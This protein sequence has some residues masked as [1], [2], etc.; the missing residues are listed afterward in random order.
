M[1]DIEIVSDAFDAG[2]LILWNLLQERQEREVEPA[3]EEPTD[4]VVTAG[5][6]QTSLQGFGTTLRTTLGTSVAIAGPVKKVE[7]AALP[8]SA[9]IVRQGSRLLKAGVGM[10]GRHTKSSSKKL[11]EL[12]V[13]P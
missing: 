6:Q 9:D 11:S 10:K 12:V 8:F 13:P 7:D 2:E 4:V 5:L 3:D 1:S